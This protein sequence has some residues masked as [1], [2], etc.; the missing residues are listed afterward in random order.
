FLSHKNKTKEKWQIFELGFFSLLTTFNICVV[1]GQNVTLLFNFSAHWL[2]TFSFCKHCA[3]AKIH[4]LLDSSSSC[5]DIYIVL[6][7]VPLLQA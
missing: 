4:R 7:H 5:Y 6:W 1:A 3:I 2:L